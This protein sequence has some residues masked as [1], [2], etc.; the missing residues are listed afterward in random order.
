MQEQPKKYE[1]HSE[2]FD[3]NFTTLNQENDSFDDDSQSDADDFNDVVQDI[4]FSQF[5]GEFKHSLKHV[6]K[7][8]AHKKKVKKSRKKLPLNSVFEVEHGATMDGKNGRQK[9][10]KKVL[11]PKNRNLIVQGVDKFILSKT[12]DSNSVRNIGYYKGEKLK[13]LIITFNNNS[14]V[15]FNLELFNPSMPLD[16]LFSTSLNLNDKVQIAAGDAV[17]YTDVLHYILANPT[18][19][20]NCKFTFSSTN[21]NAQIKEALFFKNKSI[22]GAQKIKPLQLNLQVDTMQVANDIVFFDIIGNLGRPFIPDGMDVIQYKVLAGSTVTFGFYYKQH[23]LKK[24]LF[25]EAK[26]SKGLL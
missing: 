1:S 11:V 2:H 24:L 3:E 19:I 16:Y 10:I 25:K 20:A 21:L 15:D 7:A 8:I 18:L 22:K 13:E 26:D 4:D 5:K 17:S 23:E 6:D 12:D 9:T 14:G